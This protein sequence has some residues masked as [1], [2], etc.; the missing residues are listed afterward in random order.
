[1]AQR[2]QWLLP[3]LPQGVSDLP[4]GRQDAAQDWTEAPMTGVQVATLA[5]LRQL[6]EPVVPGPRSSIIRG[7]IA[8]RHHF[9]V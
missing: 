6:L 9:R 8:D 7:R 3:D 5:R 1:V 2:G 4:D